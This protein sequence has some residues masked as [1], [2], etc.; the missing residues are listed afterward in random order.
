MSGPV[1]KNMLRG[2]AL[3][4][5]ALAASCASTRDKP[6]DRNRVDEMRRGVVD[7]AASPFRDIGLVRPEVP[8]TLQGLKY[9]YSNANLTMGCDQVLYE[10]GQLD[11]ILGAESFQPGAERGIS[12]K[13]L[14]AVE[15][16]V[17]NAARDAAGDIIPYRGWVRRISGAAKAEKEATKAIIQGQTRRA[18]LR[19][20]GAA[21][22]CLNAVPAPPPVTTPQP[23]DPRTPPPQARDQ[24]DAQR[25]R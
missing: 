19:G 22:G 21:L 16:A 15:D 25:P 9:P 3:A 5:L 2:M 7:V 8:R 20:Y 10:I 12:A 24:R 14:D 4:G 17:L 23:V 13:G 18:Y 11:A 6:D 1:W